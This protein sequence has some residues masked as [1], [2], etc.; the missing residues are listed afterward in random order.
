MILNA[1]GW[2]R[3]THR[4]MRA[5]VLAVRCPY[6]ISKGLCSVTKVSYHSGQEHFPTIG[7][8]QKLLQYISQRTKPF[9]KIIDRY[10]LFQTSPKRL[11]IWSANN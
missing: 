9:V 1:Y 11:K 6:I 10:Q 8:S 7:N 3:R 2:R 4:S 5:D